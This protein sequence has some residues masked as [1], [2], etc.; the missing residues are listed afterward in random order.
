MMKSHLKSR[1][2]CRTGTSNPQQMI[3]E[4]KHRVVVALNKLA[5]RDTF[6]IGIDE[7]EKT[8]QHLS[9][10]E[11]TPFLYCILDVD[12]AHKTA[13]RRECIRLIGVL[14]SFHE[15][16]VSSHLGK[17]VVGVVKR[18]KDPDSV[19][20]DACVETMG[21]LAVKLGGIESCDAEGVF[22]A[23]VKPLFEILGEQNK[24]LQSGSA[25]CLARVIHNT[26]YPPI[27]I[28]HRMLIRTVKFLKNP[29]FL[30]K[31]AVIQLNST[32]I[33][34]G[35]ASTPNSL[36]AAMTSIQEALKSSDWVTRK[37]ASAALGEIASSGGSD[38]SSLRAS[39]ICSLESCRFDKV[40]FWY[41]NVHA[42]MKCAALA[43]LELLHSIY[44][45]MQVKPVRDTVLH[46][47]HLWRSLVGS[48]TPACSDTGSSLKETFSGGGY[49]DISSTGESTSKAVTST[50]GGCDSVKKRSPLSSRKVAQKTK[51]ISTWQVEIAVP[52]NHISNLAD[53]RNEESE[54]S[55]VTKTFE[56]AS[57]DISSSQY[58]GFEY[59]PVDD[60]QETSSVSIVVTDKF[61]TKLVPNFH[62]SLLREP[63]VMETGIG[64]HFSNEEVSADQQTCFV[65]TQNRGSLDSIVTMSSSQTIGTCC[66]Q[67]ANDMI[68][69][70]KHLLEIENKQS[71]LLD[72]L[73]M[74]TINTA[75]SLSLIHMKVSVLEDVVGKMSQ[76]N[77]GRCFEQSTFKLSKR[78]TTLAS[79]RLSVCTPR[80]S[81]EICNRQPPFPKR[82]NEFCEEKTSSRSKLR[83][84]AEQGV[85][86]WTESRNSVAEG[87]HKSSRHGVGGN[88]TKNLGSA[89]TSNARY[90]SSEA[91]DSP[92]T[93]VIGHLSKGDLDAAYTE[94]LRSG[95]DL[96]LI[97]LLEKTGPVLEELSEKTANDVLRTLA[98]YF[99]EQ[100]FIN[101]MIPWLQ[102]VVDLS[103]L[104]G[105]NY[106]ALSA[107]AR[108]EFLFAI[109]EAV[110]IGFSNSA[111][112]RSVTQLVMKLH[113][114]WGKCA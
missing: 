13:V 48:D 107:K 44:Y 63:V 18:L 113:Q 26:S 59:V 17:I 100:R 36:Y 6:Q 53:T 30:A 111:E 7:L 8:I 38:F 9:P 25:L 88:Q 52:K 66:L 94:A 67:T 83:S 41:L 70:R 61:K 28:L 87:I 32:I 14:A 40:S 104:H 72:M 86:I 5:D 109:Q 79:P 45:L 21:V 62:N 84:S 43:K 46:A 27:T 105:P 35:G 51:E 90:Y 68:M 112:R 101:S 19:V 10:D 58:N 74:F 76:L 81:V 29:H 93:L 75:E 91:K 1:A 24:Q 47:L 80:P 34:A 97:E 73:K 103:A 99:L 37:A 4:L 102:Q 31:P 39:C 12:C 42:N 2:I 69:V 57:N 77:G 85:S 82:G 71:E 55:S 106:L 50:K 22:V 64:K 65:K 56:M 95:D 110:N 16:Q 15:V 108:R 96:V 78:S 3:F 33:Q 11:V 114:I 49:G 89:V 54:G 98:T 23:L 92:W 20:R 60:K